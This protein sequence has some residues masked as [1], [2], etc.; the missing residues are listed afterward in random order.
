M[1]TGYMASCSALKNGPHKLVQF[2]QANV[3]VATLDDLQSKKVRHKEAIE[4][5]KR[6]YQAEKL[7]YS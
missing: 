3:L 6:K 4:E 2:Q 1:S 5:N 7:K